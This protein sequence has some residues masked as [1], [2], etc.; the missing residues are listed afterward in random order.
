MIELL[1]RVGPNPSSITP[2]QALAIIGLALFALAFAGLAVFAEGLVY[3]LGR[4]VLRLS[5]QPLP[6]K[7]PARAA[8]DDL[9]RRLTKPP[10][11]EP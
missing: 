2:L 6:R 11:P 9:E 1:G 5:G 4:L 10:P 7:S 8:L 3:R